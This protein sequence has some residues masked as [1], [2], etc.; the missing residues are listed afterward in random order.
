VPIEDLSLFSSASISSSLSVRI[1]LNLQW[2][3]KWAI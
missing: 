2:N 1:R 3:S